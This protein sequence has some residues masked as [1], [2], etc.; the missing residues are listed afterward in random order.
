MATLRQLAI[1]NLP[2]VEIWEQGLLSSTTLPQGMIQELIAQV[3]L[4]NLYRQGALT[5]NLDLD[6]FAYILMKENLGSLLY[7]YLLDL[8]AVIAE[9]FI[10]YVEANEDYQPEDI[11]DADTATYHQTGKETTISIEERMPIAL[12]E[13][14]A[15]LIIFVSLPGRLIGGNYSFDTADISDLL[16]FVV[17]DHQKGFYR[18]FSV[19][20]VGDNTQEISVVGTK[21]PSL[22][23]LLRDVIVVGDNISLRLYL[24]TLKPKTL[25]PKI[26]CALQ[27]LNDEVV[28]NVWEDLRTKKIGAPSKLEMVPLDLADAIDIY[29]IGDYMYI[30]NNEEVVYYT[31][32]DSLLILNALL[33]NGDRW[34]LEDISE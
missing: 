30:M 26:R 1:K 28:I 6:L 4:E 29:R 7:P 3:T 25:K 21:I 8:E 11:F 2:V 12:Q 5:S 19:D 13:L 15:D 14:L 18:L 27:C 33:L 9:D 20:V 10:F 16:K 23:Q 32:E 31:T 17:W 34:K 24:E 22:D